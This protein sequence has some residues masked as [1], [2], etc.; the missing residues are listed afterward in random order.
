V[1]GAPGTEDRDSCAAGEG[2]TPMKGVG[3]G[4]GG[5]CVEGLVIGHVLGRVGFQL[6]AREKGGMT[7]IELLIY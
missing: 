6:D 1:G 4:K 7:A 2:E 3:R 5:G